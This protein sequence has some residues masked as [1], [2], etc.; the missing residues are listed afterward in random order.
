MVASQKH[1]PSWGSHCDTAPNDPSSW[2]NPEKAMSQ[3]LLCKLAL[4]TCEDWASFAKCLAILGSAGSETHTAAVEGAGHAVQVPRAL[5][6]HV[7]L[8]EEG[9]E[10]ALDHQVVMDHAGEG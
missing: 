1:G 4:L 9:E 8:G 10:W 2:G 5:W 6:S 3:Q 7:A